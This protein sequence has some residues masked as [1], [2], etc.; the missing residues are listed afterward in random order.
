MQLDR[1]AHLQRGSPQPL[2][3]FLT[4]ILTTIDNAYCYR[5]LERLLSLMT[6]IVTVTPLV[7]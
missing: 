6:I 3:R 7:H 1:V 2:D 4:T 5:Y